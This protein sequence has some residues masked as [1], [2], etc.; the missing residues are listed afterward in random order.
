MRPHIY[1]SKSYVMLVARFSLCIIT[2]KMQIAE[3]LY[4]QIILLERYY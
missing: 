2:E 3:V 4:Y 1:V